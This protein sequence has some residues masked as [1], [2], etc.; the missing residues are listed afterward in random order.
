MR[1]RLATL[2]R[3]YSA[4]SGITPVQSSLLAEA[5]CVLRSR[6]VSEQVIRTTTEELE[7]AF[8]NHPGRP[9]IPPRPVFSGIILEFP[10]R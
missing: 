5:F 9:V 7:A 3:A 8:E 4:R 10:R 2:Y 1:D 6:G